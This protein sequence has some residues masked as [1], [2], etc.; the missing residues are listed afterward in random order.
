MKIT[1]KIRVEG[2]KSQKV[3]ARGKTTYW[4]TKNYGRTSYRLPKFIWDK[5]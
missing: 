5:L 1:F 3:D 2:I 4:I